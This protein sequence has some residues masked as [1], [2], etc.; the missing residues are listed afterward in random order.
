[1]SSVRAG[2]IVDQRPHRAGLVKAAVAGTDYELLAE[3][4]GEREGSSAFS[5]RACLASLSNR[6]RADHV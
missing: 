4:T 6:P 2:S 5:R 1:M 3:E